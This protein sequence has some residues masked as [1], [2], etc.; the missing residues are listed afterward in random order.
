MPENSMLVVL[1]FFLLYTAMSDFGDENIF[2]Q[3]SISWA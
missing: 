3:R 2:G 1:A